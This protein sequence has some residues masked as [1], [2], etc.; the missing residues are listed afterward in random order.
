[1][2]DHWRRQHQPEHSG[3]FQ[4]FHQLFQCVTSSGAKLCQPLP[5]PSIYVVDHTGMPGG[6]QPLR[7]VA[8][9]AAQSN[10]SNLH[11]VSLS[12]FA[13]GFRIRSMMS[14]GTGNTNVEVLSPATWVSVCRYRSCKAAGCSESTWAASESAWAAWRSPSA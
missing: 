2:V 14:T 11:Q 3:S 13:A 1:G 12:L 9:H 6:Y 10:H 7:H 4:C 8:A 5:C